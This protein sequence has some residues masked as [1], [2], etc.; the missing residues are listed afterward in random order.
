LVS[1]DGKIEST[2]CTKV[3]GCRRLNPRGELLVLVSELDGASERQ[4]LNVFELDITCRLVF[5]IARI[6]LRNNAV[7][8]VTVVVHHENVLDADVLVLQ[9]RLAQAANNL[10]EILL[11][12]EAL[13]AQRDAGHDCLFLLD[14]HA[15]VI[16]HGA[17]IEV[18]LDTEGEAEHQRQQQQEPGSET[19][20]L[21]AKSH[22][23]TKKGVRASEV[24]SFW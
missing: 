13:V 24:V 1:L 7:E 17:E 22:A 18:V 21:G 5:A 20:Y 8:D 23:E 14:Y 19:L 6:E 15:S 4:H 10:V 9:Q 3:S 12:L 11:A 2:C 16:A